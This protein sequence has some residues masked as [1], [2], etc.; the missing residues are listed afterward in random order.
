MH[1]VIFVKDA[2]TGKFSWKITNL[3]FGEKV[4]NWPQL[5]A[6]FVKIPEFWRAVRN[7]AFFTTSSS[8]VVILYD[9]LTC[10][11]KTQNSFYDHEWAIL[12]NRI[13]AL[14]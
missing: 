6:E 12:L 7:E 2:N 5:C 3:P 9:N 1:N 11:V 14:L 13:A 4:E 8:A 10:T